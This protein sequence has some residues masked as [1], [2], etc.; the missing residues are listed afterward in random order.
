MLSPP[1]SAHR[2]A[3]HETAR[4]STEI[5]GP[6]RPAFVEAPKENPFGKELAQL[7]EVAEEFGQV[8]KSAEADADAVYMQ[9][10]GL[11]YHH[12]SEYMLEIQ[13]LILD[14]FSDEQVALQD[15]VF[16]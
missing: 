13:S 5:F 10:H 3:F 15:F 14:M 16:F 1:P 2:E 4:T 11:A 8:V 6:S 9:S 12:A 7:D